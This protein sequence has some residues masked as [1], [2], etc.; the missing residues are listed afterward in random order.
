[1]Y[2]YANIF[3]MKRGVQISVAIL[4]LGITSYVSYTLIINWHNKELE[5]AK[6][7]VREELTP[8]VEPIVPKEKLIEAFGEDP[9]EAP[10]DRQQTAYEEIERRIMTF[11]F[12]LDAQEYIKS[13]KLEKGT[14]HQFELT[15]NKLSANPPL[16]IGETESL[17]TLYKNMSHLYKVLGKM[18]INLIKDIIIHE[19]GLLESAATTFY[20]WVTTKNS[21]AGQQGKRP[22]MK[23]LYEYSGFFLTTLSGKSYLLRRDSI[24]NP[25]GT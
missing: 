5:N 4:M 21:A 15:V 16:V 14:Y 6:R 22:S 3:S 1:M 24:S 9:T 20:S 10:F 12:Y 23:V 25:S 18:R 8:I 17:Y 11:F 7:Q 2:V 13:Y 19:S